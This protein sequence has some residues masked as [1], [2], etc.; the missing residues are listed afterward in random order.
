MHGRIWLASLLLLTL[1]VVASPA[2]AEEAEGDM[3]RGAKFYSD[4]CGRCHN[5]RPPT[6]HRDRDWSIVMIHMRMIAG[7]PGR[8]ARDIEAFLR[9][10]NNP[11]RPALHVKPRIPAAISGEELIVRY[12]C[13]G[14]HL[15]GGQGGVIGPELD[16]VFKRRDEEWIRAQIRDPRQ[17]NPATVMPVFGFADDQ[18]EAI[19]E[20][21]RRTQ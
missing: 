1:T 2:S 6:E 8:Q 11:P 4:N 13:N 21:L 19:I 9:A 12:G 16:T 17:H 14:C 7:I 10:A 18:V 5:A 3:S 15:I 20:A